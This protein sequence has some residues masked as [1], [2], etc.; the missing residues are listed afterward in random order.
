MI[1]AAVRTVR[2]LPMGARALLLQAGLPGLPLVG[3]HCDSRTYSWPVV[4]LAQREHWQALCRSSPITCHSQ[5]WPARAETGTR[6]RVE[7]SRQSQQQMLEALNHFGHFI[8]CMCHF[9][10]T[11]LGEE[12]MQLLE[13]AGSPIF[14]IRDPV[15]R[16]KMWDGVQDGHSKTLSP[17]IVLE[18]NSK[19]RG[20]PD[21]ITFFWRFYQRSLESS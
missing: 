20:L 4:L 9:I 19:K 16:N 1:K 12:H 18:H 11:A 13:V 21:F 14:F 2:V 8:G 10:K 6:V 15:P 3:I 5:H 17:C 7:Q